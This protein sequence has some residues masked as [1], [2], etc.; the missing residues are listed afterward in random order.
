MDILKEILDVGKKLHELNASKANALLYTFETEEDPD[1]DK[2]ICE[3]IFNNSLT[4]HIFRREQWMAGL[5]INVGPS[6]YK[7]LSEIKTHELNVLS[8][9]LLEK[10]LRAMFD[11]L[12]EALEE[13]KASATRE[14]RPLELS[15]EVLQGKE[16]LAR[17]AKALAAIRDL[18]SF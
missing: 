5:H 4:V 3:R 10:K 2:R 15:Q 11:P 12:F 17:E 14:G 13:E 18:D 7:N 16:K 9:Q 8:M 1:G 6:L